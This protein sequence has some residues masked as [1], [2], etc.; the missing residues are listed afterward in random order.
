[1]AITLPF[2]EQFDLRNLPKNVHLF[3]AVVCFSSSCFSI[4]D[5]GVFAS[6]HAF[7]PLS[8]CRSRKLQRIQP[9]IK[10]CTSTAILLGGWG[11]EGDGG[12]GDAW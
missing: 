6:M 2:V 7:L 10:A 3:T 8:G 1:M 5:T 4:V 11:Y 9:G 12:D